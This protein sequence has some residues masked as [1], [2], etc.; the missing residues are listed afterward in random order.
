MIRFLQRF[1]QVVND[2]PER[3]A[4]VDRDGMRVTAYRELYD[5]A[6]RVNAW[7]REQGVGKEDVIAIYYPKGLE[8]IVTRIGIIMSGAAWVGLEDIMGRDRIDFVIRDCDCRIVFDMDVWNEAML[9]EPCNDQAKSAEHDLAFYIYT[10]GST[11]NPKGAA[12]EYGVYDLIMEGTF[13]FLGRTVYPEGRDH[14]PV[15]LQFAHVIPETFVGGVFITVGIIN[16]GSTIH[17]ISQEMTRNPNELIKYFLDHKID[18]TFMTPTFLNE[19][20]KIPGIA[21]RGGYTGGEIVSGIYSEAFEIINV[22]GTSEFGYPACIFVIDRSY[23]N[24]PVGYPVCDSSIILIDDNG[25]EADEGVLCIYLPYFRG[26]RNLPEEDR[27][28]ET[29]I[30]GRKYFKSSDYARRDEQGRYTI[31][32][33]ADSMIKIN[34]NRV[35]PGEVEAAVKKEFN[36]DFCVVRAVNINGISVLAAYYT[37]KSMPDGQDVRKR[38]KKRIPEY[39]IPSYYVRIDEIPLNTVGK[40]D[41]KMLPVPDMTGYVREYKEPANETEKILRDVFSQVFKTAG[42]IG[43]DDDFFLLGG[44]SI[45]AMKCIVLAKIKDLTVQM[46]FEGRTVREIARLLNEE[47]QFTSATEKVHS[48]QIEAPLNSSQL[49]LLRYERKHPGTTMLNIPI[50]FIM[51][52]DVDLYEVADAIRK[53]L[54]QHP[55]ML[56]T[57][58]KCGDEYV[59]KYRPDFDREIYIE[60]VSEEELDDIEKN[61]VKPFILDGT[62]LFRCRILRSGLRKIVLFD[63]Y[64]VI[65]DGYSYDFFVEEIGHILYKRSLAKDSFYDILLEDNSSRM[66][67]RHEKDRLYFKNRYDRIGY[68]TLPLKDHDGVENV[69][70]TIMTGFTHKRTDAERIGRKYGLGKTGFY[71]AA[72]ILAMAA[73]NRKDRIMITWTWNG[74]SDERK[75]DSVGVLIADIP[76]AVELN[77]RLT[78]EGLLSDISLQIR[79]GIKHD[80]ISYWED[81][82]TYYGEDL[83]CLTYQGNLYEYPA[84]EYVESIEI[85][86]SD[87]DACYNSMNVDILDSNEDYEIMIHYNSGLYDED[88]VKRFG[89]LICEMCERIIMGHGDGSFVPLH[90]L[91]K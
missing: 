26:Y 89:R 80:S 43:T 17:V 2:H 11:G 85:M 79:E 48:E 7:L 31:L 28:C 88:S 50:K 36:T 22:Y 68:S 67:G 56:S 58:E 49:Y 55:V 84:D 86:Q 5:K 70:N 77:D 71:I 42:S 44:D 27:N 29:V 24:T 16:V 63:V 69:D 19:I 61:F 78:I 4:V 39:M 3:I 25:Y 81:K 76:V 20:Q 10:S 34:G 9:C 91:S 45:I 73:Y 62:P 53:A 57:I 90:C 1:E 65:C 74:R 35:E 38:L 87:N 32:G 33:R 8:Y 72:V 51:K 52:E 30:K 23:D 83:L 64:H 12:Q 46:I 40:I 18:S 15:Q 59:L 47:K 54:K 60:T 21:I 75:A 82:D 41:R 14:A 37:D 13:G 6:L 66:S